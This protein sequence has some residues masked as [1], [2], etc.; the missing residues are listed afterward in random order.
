LTLGAG[1]TF[2]WDVTPRVDGELEGT[3]WTYLRFLPKNGGAEIRQPV[4]AQMVAIRTRSV[5]GRGG[6]DM[7]ISGVFGLAV[8]LV[9]A[10]WFV[11]ISG[12]MSPA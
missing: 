3:V 6:S 2:Y 7:R 4:A 9:S 11:R 10:F 12:K 5:L 8:G 1:A